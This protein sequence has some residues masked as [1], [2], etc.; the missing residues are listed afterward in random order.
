MG[1]MS[2]MPKLYQKTEEE[3]T[4]SSSAYEISI[5]RNQVQTKT[6]KEK[7]ATGHHFPWEQMLKL[8]IKYK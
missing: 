1:K 3:R 6:L 8:S 5:T 4:L 2:V 7:K